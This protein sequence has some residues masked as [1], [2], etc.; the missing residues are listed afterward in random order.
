METIL[1]FPGFLN[2]SSNERCIWELFFLCIYIFFYLLSPLT[3]FI[4]PCWIVEICS[5]TKIFISC[6]SHSISSCPLTFLWHFMLR[7]SL[8]IILGYSLFQP[9]EVCCKFHTVIPWREVTHRLICVIKHKFVFVWD[10]FP[11]E[12]RSVSWFC[13]LIFLK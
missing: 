7:S 9:V 5:R 11:E 3:S 2:R 10:V 1:F 13:R 4:H 8:S 12:L 6:D